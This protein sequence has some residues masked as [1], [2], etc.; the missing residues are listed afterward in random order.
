[1]NR[2]SVKLTSTASAWARGM[3]RYSMGLTAGTSSIPAIRVSMTGN[4][5]SVAVTITLLER[6]SATILALTSTAGPSSSSSL[7]VI[8]F[9]SPRASS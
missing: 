5:S 8:P 1:M 2:D 9:V 7:I 6:R 3:I 4:D